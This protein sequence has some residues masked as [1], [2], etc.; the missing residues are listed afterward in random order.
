MQACWLGVG[1]GLGGLAG[2]VLMQQAGG[3]GLF[4]TCTAV[5]LGAWGTAVAARRAVGG[6]AGVGLPGSKDY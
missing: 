1:T 2:G 3:R 5:M 6:G 4:A